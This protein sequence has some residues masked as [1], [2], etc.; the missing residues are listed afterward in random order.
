MDVSSEHQED[1]SR[2]SSIKGSVTAQDQ[3]ESS[4][5]YSEDQVERIVHSRTQIN[6]ASSQVTS[7]IL[8]AQI[9]TLKYFDCFTTQLF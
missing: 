6:M 5:S 2:G 7:I 9:S 3:E 1:R 4:S 8:T